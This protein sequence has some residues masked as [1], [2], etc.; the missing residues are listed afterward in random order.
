MPSQSGPD[1]ELTPD[2]LEV[3]KGINEET[4]TLRDIDLGET[5]PATVFE[6]G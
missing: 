2:A 4:R 1:T 3:L 5:P 6:A